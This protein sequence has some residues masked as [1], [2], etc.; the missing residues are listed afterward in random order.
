MQDVRRRFR[1]RVTDWVAPEPTA[2]DR[3]RDAAPLLL[4]ALKDCFAALNDPVIGTINADDPR[5]YK[6]VW[7]A[8]DKARAAIAAAEGGE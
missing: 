6:L 5:W 4:E 7:D 3:I 8:R 1:D 2:D